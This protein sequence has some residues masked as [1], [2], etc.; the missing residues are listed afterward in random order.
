MSDRH[1]NFNPG[2]S[3]L[4]L[5]VLERAQREFLDYEGSGMSLIEH[6]HRGAVYE[7]VHNEAIALLRETLDVPDS[8]EVLFMHGGASTQFALIPMNLRSDDHA[9]DYVVTGTWAKKALDEAKVVGDP[10]VAWNGESDGKWERVPKADE[11]DLTDDA[12]YVHLTTNNTIM[13][14]QFF[15]LPQ[16]KAPL[17]LD[18]SSDI[19]WRPMDIS[20]IGMV[21]AGA[22]K[23]MGPSG[24][25]VVIV[26]KDLIEKGRTDLPKI[27]RYA[28]VAK[29][30]SLQNTIATFPVYMV[31]NVLQWVKEQGGTA[32]M[33]AHNRA[34]AEML[35]GAVDGSDGYYRC[36]VERES[37]SIMNAVFRLPDATLEK[38]F[39]A[40]ATNAGLVGL[41][42]HRDVGGIRVSMYNAM[43]QA[44]V[45]ALVDFMGRF[46]SAN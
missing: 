25:T 9:G 7:A 14:T 23:N 2:P 12:P 31:R 20:K 19:L 6:S 41:K 33:E 38:K 32:A 46:K 3:T 22:Q 44:G 17:I 16:T 5:P 34:K 43:P 21:Y 24:I 28:T 11:L 39:V 36:P 10:H 1:Y 26:R 13:G 37:R 18:M 35:Y 30:N 45:A 8:H 40:D 4:P 27:F 15:D 42:G 29:A